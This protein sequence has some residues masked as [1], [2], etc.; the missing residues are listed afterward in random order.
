MGRHR[1]NDVDSSA[2]LGLAKPGDEDSHQQRVKKGGWM[3]TRPELEAG[4]DGGNVDWGIFFL[5]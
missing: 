5:P 2:G 1:Q 4:G 3:S